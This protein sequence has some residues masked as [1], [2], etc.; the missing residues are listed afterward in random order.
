MLQA[1]A[2]SISQA[3]CACAS[4]TAAANAEAISR[5]VATASVTGVPAQRGFIGHISNQSLSNARVQGLWGAFLARTTAK[6]SRTDCG[7]WQAAD[8]AVC[9]VT[10]TAC[11]AG[12][13]TSTAEATGTATNT[14]VVRT[15]TTQLESKSRVV[16]MWHGC[17][18]CSMEDRPRLS[19]PCSQRGPRP[20]GEHLHQ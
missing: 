14:A 19:A 15:T 6:P 11:A 9:A 2:T 1:A 20:P 13:A 5:N 4:A 7:V 10:A 16:G 18:A 12:G 3:S 8:A 17:G